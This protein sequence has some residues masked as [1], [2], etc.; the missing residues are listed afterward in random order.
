MML[1]N[2]Y[3]R[4]LDHIKKNHC[5]QLA[6]LCYNN[7]PLLS[8]TD[9]EGRTLLHHAA[10][11]GNVS[12]CQVLLKENLG[13]A[14]LDL[15]DVYGKTALHYAIQMHNSTVLKFLVHEEAK[16]DIPDCNSQTVLD[17]A[18]NLIEW[19]VYCEGRGDGT[20]PPIG[21]LPSI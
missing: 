21:W 8:C 19:H 11:H 5:E 1:Q 12:I 9:T 10:A 4:A 17:L 6:G 3:H 13:R 2:P 15:Q 16:Y 7:L 14:Q 18:L 20:S